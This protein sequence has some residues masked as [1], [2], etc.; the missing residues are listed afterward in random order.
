M[1]EVI[2]A[3]AS[4]VSDGMV[5]VRDTYLNSVWKSGGVPVLLQPRSDTEYV[6][7]VASKF[8]GFVFCG[9]EDIDPKYYGEENVASKNICSVRDEFEEALF[10]A[11]Y[12]TGKPI[13]GI[14]RGMQVI[15]VFLG[16]SLHQHI[17]GHVQDEHR[18]VRTHSVSIQ[19]DSTLAKI[20]GEENIDVNSFHHQVV[21]KLADTLTV[22]AVNGDGYIE[23]C[24]AVGQ[25][26]LLC[27]Q[28]HPESYY[29]HCDTSRK[30]FEAFIKAC[31]EFRISER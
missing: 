8:D 25:R 17:D 13:L 20:L 5:S 26:F 23:A 19:S 28:W 2:I 14:C 9:G 12:K 11:V 29:D 7:Q 3:L 16:G 15:N 4:N 30:I 31:E 24:H 1:N 27:V 10:K 6:S 21:K 22:D 18:S